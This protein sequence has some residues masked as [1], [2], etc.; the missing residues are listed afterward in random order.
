MG[1]WASPFRRDG[2]QGLP[3]LAAGMLGEAMAEAN[4]GLAWSWTSH[5]NLCLDAIFRN[6]NEDSA[7]ATCGPCAKVSD[8]R[9]GHDRAR[10]RLRRPRL[11]GHDGGAR[12]TRTS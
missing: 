5:D 10:R 1:F 6:G 3:Y 11:H 2:G 4:P 12:A 7:A 8:R 9:P